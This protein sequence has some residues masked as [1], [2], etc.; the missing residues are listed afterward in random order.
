MLC[1]GSTPSCDTNTTQG[2]C[3]GETGCSWTAGCT[4]SSSVL[5]SAQTDEST[6]TSAGCLWN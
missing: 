1:S 5:C 3:T 2:G 4:G 6:C